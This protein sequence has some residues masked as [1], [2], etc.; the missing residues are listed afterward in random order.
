MKETKEI[1]DFD[2]VIHKSNL[3]Q[4]LVVIRTGNETCG[5][6]WIDKNGDY[7]EEN[8]YKGELIVVE[9]YKI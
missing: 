7:H 5:C 1:K 3:D 8:F 9:E 2:V 4:R 6:S